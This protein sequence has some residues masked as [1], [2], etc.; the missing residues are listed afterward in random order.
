MIDMSKLQ[1]AGKKTEA[2]LITSRKQ[3]ETIT[4]IIDGYTIKTQLP[5]KYLG[6]I[7]DG[8]CA[9]SLGSSVNGQ[10]RRAKPRDKTTFS[11][12]QSISYVVCGTCLGAG[13]NQSKKH[14]RV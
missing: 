8:S 5:I 7:I 4:L 10:H 9:S 3:L 14:R 1:L 12:S 6:I 11:K 2:A 13:K